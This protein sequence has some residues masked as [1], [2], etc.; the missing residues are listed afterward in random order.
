MERSGITKNM[1]STSRNSLLVFALAALVLVGGGCLGQGEI[2]KKDDGFVTPAPTST[3]VVTVRPEFPGMEDVMIPEDWKEFKDEELGISFRYPGYMRF[4]SMSVESTNTGKSLDHF[5]FTLSSYPNT[6][7]AESISIG[8]ATDAKTRNID[9]GDIAKPGYRENVNQSNPDMYGGEYAR[10][11]KSIESGYRF[12]YVS[13]EAKN[14]NCLDMQRSEDGRKILQDY[15]G[16]LKSLEIKIAPANGTLTLPKIIRPEFPR[17]GSEDI[18]IPADWKE[19][20]DESLGISFRYSPEMKLVSGA[21]TSTS[22]FSF[23]L[24]SKNPSVCNESIAI[25]ITTDT[26]A[27]RMGY[28][29][30][31]S[32]EYSEDLEQFSPVPRELSYTYDVQHA[33]WVQTTGMD[34]KFY[35][36]SGGSTLNCFHPFGAVGEKMI[37]DYKR[38][39]KSLTI[40]VVSSE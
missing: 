14:S 40:Q 18:E 3:S 39:L 33:W 9:N 29:N 16:V 6:V 30:K 8:L 12:Y 11:V 13:G 27:Q 10:W 32:Q 20:K 17:V 23:L 4:V 31:V 36:V 19:F 25:G 22:S 28:K 37:R 5:Y 15:K 2:P 38:V 26:I 34:Y 7:C 24:T 1:N 21:N 35:Y